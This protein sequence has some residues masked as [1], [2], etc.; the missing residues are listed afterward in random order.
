MQG[1]AL[2]LKK[3][4]RAY[5]GIEISLQDLMNRRKTGSVEMPNN[6]LNVT[7]AWGFHHRRYGSPECYS[8]KYYVIIALS[9]EALG[10]TD[11]FPSVVVPVLYILYQN[12]G[13]S[14]ESKKPFFLCNAHEIPN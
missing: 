14:P 12:K 11:T 4:H 13:N 9:T 7:L 8:P 5:S 2:G 3:N 1:S 6:K 10:G